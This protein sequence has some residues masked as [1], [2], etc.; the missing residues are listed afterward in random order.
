MH[1][2]CTFPFVPWQELSPELSLVDLSNLLTPE[3]GPTCCRSQSQKQTQIPPS[4][5]CRGAAFA[6]CPASTQSKPSTSKKYRLRH[7]TAMLWRDDAEPA[8]M[9]QPSGN[10]EKEE[11]TPCSAPLR[12]GEDRAL[13]CFFGGDR[14]KQDSWVLLH[15]SRTGGRMGC[16]SRSWDPLLIDFSWFIASS[17]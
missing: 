2:F 9:L 4:C 17:L 12:R 7:R 3:C 14:M 6:P 15:L 16:C 10:L 13:L 1:V 11:A 5:R 8:A